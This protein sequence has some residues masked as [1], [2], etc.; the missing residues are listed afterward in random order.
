L[1]HMN[2]ASERVRIGLNQ[3]QMAERLGVSVA[4]LHAYE[5]GKRKIPQSALVSAADLF[6]C[7][8]DYLLD[9]TP[10]RMARES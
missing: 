2:M 4:T 9:R 7:S 6:G 1:Q 5:T 8:V 10:E 3:T